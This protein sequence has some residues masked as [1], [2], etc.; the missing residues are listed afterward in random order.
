MTSAAEI[1]ETLS[2]ANMFSGLPQPTLDRIAAIC[3]TCEYG[4]D[5][6]LYRA[7][8]EARNIFVLM[9]GRV[10]FTLETDPRGTSS[11]SVM[12][13]RMVIG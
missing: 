12:S 6:Y 10:L 1:V 13:N 11:G 7:G 2:G 8:D 4:T 5:D 9:S 3:E